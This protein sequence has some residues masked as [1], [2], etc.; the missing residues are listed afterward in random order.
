MRRSTGSYASVT[1]INCEMGARIKPEGWNNWG[2]ASNEQTAR[3]SEYHTK[4]AGA[5]PDKRA[6]WSHQLTDEQATKINVQ[7][8]LGGQDHWDPAVEAPARA[9]ESH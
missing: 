3:Y 7:T 1:Y 2:K 6:G 8:V 5:A 4:G 9:P